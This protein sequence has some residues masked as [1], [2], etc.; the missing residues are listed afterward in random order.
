MEQ[1]SGLVDG[2]VEVLRQSC[3]QGGLVAFSGE[4]L[5]FVLPVFCI[6]LFSLFSFL[7]SRFSFLFS[8]F[9]SIFFFLF[10]LPN[11]FLIE[12]SDKLLLIIPFAFVQAL[13]REK[14][15]R[16]EKKGAVG[17]SLEKKKR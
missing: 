7:F 5:G 10:S 2:L 15:K 17:Y 4:N 6:I 13:Q 16:E 11:F 1:E 9:F 8:L 3:P 12:K 14:E